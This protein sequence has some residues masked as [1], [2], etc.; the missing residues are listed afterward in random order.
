LQAVYEQKKSGLGRR[1]EEEFNPSPYLIRPKLDLTDNPLLNE[2]IGLGS[3]GRKRSFKPQ[4]VD[5]SKAFYGFNRQLF[6]PINIK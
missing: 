3:G 2:K 1:E 6:Y 4:P 5:S